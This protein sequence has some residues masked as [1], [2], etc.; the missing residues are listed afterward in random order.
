MK[1]WL[2][3]LLG[4]FQLLAFENSSSAAETNTVY[5]L[6]IREDIMPPLV[7][8]VR[9]G[10]KEA[11][12][13]KADVLI[14]DMDTNGGRL[15]STE[16][17]IEIL[18]QFKGKTVTYVNKKAFSA[19]A[20]ISFATQK[21]Y[22]APQSVIGAAAPIVLSSTGDG[23]EKL[24]D[25]YEAKISS[26]ASALVRASAE[27]N[28][29]NVEVADAMVKKNK[30]LKIDDKVINEKG[31]LLTLTDREAAEEYGYPAKPLLSAGT[32][33]SLNDV[34][35]IFGS[36]EATAKRIIPTG[37]EKLASWIMAIAPLLLIIGAIG[38]YV[39]IKTPGF[40]VPGIT[41]IVA[42]T[43]YFFGGYIAGL[44][45]PMWIAVFVVGLLLVASELFLHPGTIAPG[46]LGA[47]LM[48]VA[49]VMAMVDVYPGSPTLPTTPI[50]WNSLQQSFQNIVIA[51]LGTIVMVV[52][53]ARV[54][55]KTPLYNRLVS[56][57][58]SGMKT[59]HVETQRRISRDGQLGVAIS[60]L[61]PGGKAQFGNEILDV[62]SQ[63]DLL[64][65]GQKVKIIG[66][67][68]SEA[69]VEAI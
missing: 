4:L 20:Y 57:T 52:I 63:G 53:L 31:Q 58:A 69:I 18:S 56:K 24:P 5:V 35:K 54:L 13:A 17:I 25:T 33:D 39:E 36:T 49:V 19:G 59:E 3:I 9:R 47:A 30:E 11:M 46:L 43:L 45:G 68:G 38:T 62:I 61:R 6:P 29:H 26:A 41:A 42:V 44:S 60:A 34:L 27:K 66:H 37:S 10:V 8:L 23:V 15:D 50:A 28:G 22:M 65:K 7:Y 51:T 1:H 12:D 67:S 21:I 48:F 32:V 2:M 14:L 55:P 16:K 64:P 40:G